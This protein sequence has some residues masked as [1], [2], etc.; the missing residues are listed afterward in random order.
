MTPMLLP[1][2]QATIALH[3][4]FVLCRMSFISGSYMPIWR[5]TLG[6]ALTA[7][8]YSARRITMRIPTSRSV[9][10]DDATSITTSSGKRRR[11]GELSSVFKLPT[12]PT[13]PHKPSATHCASVAN[14]AIS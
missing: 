1:L 3:A 6:A 8:W 13:R 5:K 4:C 12:T 9:T 2:R 11:L 7:A 14:L 10:V